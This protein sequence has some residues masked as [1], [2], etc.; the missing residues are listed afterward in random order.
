MGPNMFELIFPV[1]SLNLTYANRLAADIAEEQ[2]C[3][4]PVAGRMMNHPAWIIGHLAWVAD[5]GVVFLGLERATPAEWKE[6][7]APSSK[8]LPERERY[9]AKPVLLRALADA[10]LRLADTVTKAAPEVLAG[11]PP[12]RMRRAFPTVK[13]ALAGLMTSHESVHLGQLSAWRRAMGLPSVF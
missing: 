6:L 5:N 8:P 12:E 2:M 9:P 4:Q 10:H 11:L 1:F 3:L 7:F 13:H